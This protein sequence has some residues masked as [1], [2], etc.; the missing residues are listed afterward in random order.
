MVLFRIGQERHRLILVV[1]RIMA[2]IF[3]KIRR[4][5]GNS[6]HNEDLDRQPS[7]FFLPKVHFWQCRTECDMPL[8]LLDDLPA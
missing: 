7:S 4:I 3:E 6:Q 5:V 8:L 2:Q 1:P